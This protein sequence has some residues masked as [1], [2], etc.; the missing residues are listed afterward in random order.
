[1]RSVIWTLTVNQWSLLKVRTFILLIMTFIFAFDVHCEWKSIAKGLDVGLFEAR[2]QSHVGNSIFTILRIDPNYWKFELIGSSWNNQYKN[3]TAREWCKSH[4]FTAAINAGMFNT[5]YETHTGYLKSK[6]HINNKKWNHYKSVAAF[7]PRKNRIPRF[8]IY[9][10]DDPK[11]SK[12][13]ILVNFSL[14]LI[15]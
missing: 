14:F 12:D 7:N 13:F 8:E 10:L 4:N 15:L 3:K 5:D 1:M 6:K 2:Q 9:D 11:I